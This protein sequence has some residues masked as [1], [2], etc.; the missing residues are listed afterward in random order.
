MAHSRNEAGGSQDV[1]SLLGAVV[2]GY[3][4]ES[5]GSTCKQATRDEQAPEG[6]NQG[7]EISS[8]NPKLSA[9]QKVHNAPML[10]VCP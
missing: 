7:E 8:D 1:V 10:A 5:V 2:N 9:W 4:L 3:L 6:V